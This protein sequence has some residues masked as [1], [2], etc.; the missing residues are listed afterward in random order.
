[1]HIT[2]LCIIQQN[3]S[4]SNPFETEEFVQ[5]RQVFGLHVGPNYIDI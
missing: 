1:M 4:K 2:P 3:L 5:F